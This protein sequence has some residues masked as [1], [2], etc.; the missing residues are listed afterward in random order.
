MPNNPD[1]VF[2]CMW[3]NCDHMFEDLADL[4]DHLLLEAT[5]HVFKVTQ[6]QGRVCV[7]VCVFVFALFRSRTFGLS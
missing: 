5:G 7:C 4:S 6:G 1:V 3:E 2:E